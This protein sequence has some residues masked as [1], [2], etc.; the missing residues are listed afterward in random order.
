MTV[1]E[2]CT[3]SVATVRPGDTV[4]EAAKR[5]RE[6]RVAG[7]VV[8]DESQRA[9]GILTD[10]DIVLRA[11]AQFPTRLATLAVSEVMSRDVATVR[12]DETLEVVLR[13]M[14]GLGVRRLPMVDA[15]GIVQGVVTLDNVL[16]VMS[17]ELRDLISLMGREMQHGPG[18]GPCESSEPASAA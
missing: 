12:A 7:L 3:R 9:V 6:W 13:R 8:T 1:G 15:D 10:R 18:R 11:V 2:M 5:M 17:D 14:R 4:L 16:G